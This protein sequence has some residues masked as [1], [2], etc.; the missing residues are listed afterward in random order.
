MANTSLNPQIYSL[1]AST[2]T[3]NQFAPA[4]LDLDR[5]WSSGYTIALFEASNRNTSYG[6][7]GP[8]GKLVTWTQPRQ[9]V[10]QQ[11][12]S[13]SQSGANLVINF[14]D[15]TYTGFRVKDIVMDDPGSNKAQVISTA[16][17]TITVCPAGSP[18]TLTNG[19]Q[20]VAGRFI[21]ATWDGSGNY[22]STGKTRL[23]KDRVPRTNY[24]AVSRDTCQVS[25]REKFNSYMGKQGV[26]YYW[27]DQETWMVQ[28]F[29]RNYLNKIIWSDPAVFN[30]PIEGVTN[31]TQGLR[32]AVRDQGGMFVQATQ[33][34]TQTQFESYFDFV[35]SKYAA[36]YQ[37]FWLLAGRNAW[38]QISSF[39][40]NQLAYTVGTKLANG[41]ALNFDVPQITIKGITMKIMLVSA[42]NDVVQWPAQTTIPGLT[43]TIKENTFCIVNLKE[44]PAA[45]GSGVISPARKFH[46]AGD[47]TSGLG[48]VIGG[49]ETI[50]KIIPGMTNFGM[51]NS[52]GASIH[53]MYQM[54]ASS[55]DG[56][57]IEM[58][59][60]NGMDFQADGWVWYEPLL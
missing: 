48:G 43:G 12:A 49:D 45:D 32:A 3:Y 8:E 19:S 25:R 7:T 11:I 20:F 16:P 52:T 2:L 15:P 9:L 60:D 17:G 38:G 54:A 50:Y 1:Y 55:I 42:F 34:L 10:V 26:A 18:T 13:T 30:S 33:A 14:V 27:S 41:T 5:D 51:G 56:A 37:D 36:P 58:L 57:Q 53:Q 4:V 6:V 47:P 22:N 40:T 28:R 31:Q 29:A 44:I 24:S 23:F 46:Y 35:A 59:M 39:Y 21:A